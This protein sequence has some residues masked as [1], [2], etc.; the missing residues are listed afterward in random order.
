M[1]WEFL[2][3]QLVASSVQAWRE[4]GSPVPPGAVPGRKAFR[5]PQHKPEMNGAKYIAL[6]A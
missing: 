4:A 6:Q 3:Q 1:A 5:N 2:R